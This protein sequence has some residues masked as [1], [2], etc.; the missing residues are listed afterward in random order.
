MAVERPFMIYLQFISNMPISELPQQLPKHLS[1]TDK[2]IILSSQCSNVYN[3]KRVIDTLLIF[4]KLI[5]Y[6]EK[7][8]FSVICHKKYPQ[9]IA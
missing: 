3:L 4:K 9:T 5:L 7:A 8:F 1:L 2:N 6:C